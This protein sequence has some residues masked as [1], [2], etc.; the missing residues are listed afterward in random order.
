MMFINPERFAAALMMAIALS[1]TAFGSEFPGS[2]RD[3]DAGAVAV[4]P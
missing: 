2:P 1:G 3:G 4:P